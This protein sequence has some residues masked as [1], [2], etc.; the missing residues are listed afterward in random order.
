VREGRVMLVTRPRAILNVCGH[1]WPSNLLSDEP[2][3]SSG[4]TFANTVI[5]AALDRNWPISVRPTRLPS[6]P[7]SWR[8]PD[9]PLVTWN[10]PF[11]G[12]G[13]A[14]R[15]RTP[16]NRAFRYTRPC[17]IPRWWRRRGRRGRWRNWGKRRRRGR[18]RRPGP[19]DWPRCRC[20]GPDAPDRRNS[21]C[22]R[23]SAARNSTGRAAS[24]KREGKAIRTIQ[25]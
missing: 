23:P 25:A 20:V 22:R 7:G 2:G 17:H 1:C 15:A 5:Y 19:R 4:T 11:G 21:D 13:P 14:L 8:T 24:V 18:W 3:E 6:P 12:P 16:G 10:P 9:G